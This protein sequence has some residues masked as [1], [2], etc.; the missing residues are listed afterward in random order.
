MYCPNCNAV[1]GYVVMYKRTSILTMSNAVKF[2]PFCGV[3]LDA[4]F[5]GT[6]A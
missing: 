6:G 2:C 1:I 5:S 3:S 4:G